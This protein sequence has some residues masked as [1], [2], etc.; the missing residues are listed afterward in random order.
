[1][2]RSGFAEM[3]IIL[4]TGFVMPTVGLG[5]WRMGG[6]DIKHLIIDAIK[7]GY[8]HFDCAGNIY[9]EI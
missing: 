7:I 3:A 6:K 5:V 8:R 4:N 9:N 2:K 1:M